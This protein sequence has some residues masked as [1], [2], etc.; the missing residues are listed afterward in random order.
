[1]HHS[2][3]IY[4]RLS[5]FRP[6]ALDLHIPDDVADPPLI[7]WIH[8]GGFSEGDRRSQPKV[9]RPRSFFSALNDAGLACATID[10]RLS[11]EAGWHAQGDDVNTAIAF[12]TERASDYG[13]DAGRLGTAGDSAG[14]HLALMTAMT[15][16]QVKATVAWYPL[17]DIN[18][19]DSE[20]G[21]LPHSPWLGGVPSQMPERMVQASPITYITG[22]SPPC[23]FIHGQLDTIYPPS[24]SETMHRKLVD[25]GVE[26]VCRIVPGAGHGLSR[27]GREQAD[28][29]LDESVAFLSQRL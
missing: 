3:V 4:A 7:V 9:I 29:M 18:A 28:A 19:L 12:L 15:N 1:M 25:A 8:G 6:L 2:E 21:G 16:P 22:R 13:I 11:G 24:Q 23:L 26:S 10:Y 5:G 27:C 14:G 17:T 20:C